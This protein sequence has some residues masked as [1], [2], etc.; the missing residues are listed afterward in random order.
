MVKVYCSIDDIVWVQRKLLQVSRIN[1]V[2]SPTDA[3]Y[4]DGSFELQPIPG[5]EG[6]KTEEELKAALQSEG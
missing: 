5:P 3:P 1:T 2:R 6:L 4:S